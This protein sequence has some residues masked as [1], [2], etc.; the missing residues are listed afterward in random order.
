MSFGRQQ[1][2]MITA[3]VTTG[4]NMRNYF[5][6]GKGTRPGAACRIRGQDYLGLVSFP[7]T[8][9]AG[10]TLF[11]M[12]I[13]PSALALT[14]TRLGLMA[15]MFEKFFFTKLIFHTT[16]QA[17]T[18]VQGS[19]ILAYDHD[20]ADA[21]PPVTD[22]GVRA[23]MSFEDS[24]SQPVWQSSRLGCTV[25]NDP[26]KFYYT[27]YVDEEERV[28][29]QG[30]VYV[31]CLT[32]ASVGSFFSLWVEYEIELYQPQLDLSAGSECVGTISN[33]A[34]SAT[35]NQAFNP[36]AN[37]VNSPVMAFQTDSAGNKALQILK[38]GYYILEQIY[39]TSSSGT[40]TSVSAPTVNALDAAEQSLTAIT[41]LDLFSAPAVSTGSAFRH[42]RIKI[43]PHGANVYGTIVGADTFAN[44][45]VRAFSSPSSSFI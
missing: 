45:V 25:K 26:Q 29:F 15:K 37:T 43:P 35:A 22:D 20:S 1:N 39:K 6:M 14:N 17:P 32:G 5:E 12:P 4:M 16:A 30:Q 28:A 23:L 38:Q 24:V 33:T 11:N 10:T 31:A 21:T 19:Y 36:L 44:Q 2:T 13:S 34:V 42:D 7:T 41:N 8:A 18:S 27:N 3:P 9:S 40:G